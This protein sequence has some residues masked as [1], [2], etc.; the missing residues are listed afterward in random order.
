MEHAPLLALLAL[1]CAHAVEAYMRGSAARDRH[2][3]SSRSA[4]GIDAATAK[5][6][7]LRH[8]SP[9]LQDHSASSTDSARS[10][11]VDAPCKCQ[12]FHPDWKPCLRSEPMCIFVDLG[13]AAGDTF[14]DFL[15]GEYGNITGCP[16]GKWKSTLIEANPRFDSQ[17]QNIKREYHDDVSLEMSTAAYMC[18][19]E[20]QLFMDDSNNSRGQWRSSLS[21]RIVNA[22]EKSSG[23]PRNT[24]KVQIVNLN[25]ILYEDTIPGDYVVVKMDI[26]G[27]EWDVVPC[28]SKSPMSNLVDAMFIKQYSW[29]QSM[30][31]SNEDDIMYSLARLKQIGVRIDIVD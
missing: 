18:D 23:D 25:R 8:I 6:T 9:S 2:A 26:G 19:T 1:V 20:A 22:S 28:L 5:A 21:P 27:A 30:A 12:N 31:G 7:G 29:K 11:R 15:H 4:G 13:A 17:L 16:G 10:G 14:R 24:T 3:A